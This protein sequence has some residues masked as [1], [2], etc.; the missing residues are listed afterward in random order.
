[1]LFTPLRRVRRRNTDSDRSLR[2]SRDDLQD[3]V[4][5]ACN[6]VA[7]QHLREVRDAALEG[8]PRL[9][10]MARREAGGKMATP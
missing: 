5:L 9:V 10:A 4:G 7:L 3:V 6:R 2:L 1:M 8:P